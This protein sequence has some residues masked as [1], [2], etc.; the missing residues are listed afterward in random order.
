MG[1]SAFRDAR[2]AKGLTQSQLAA[3]VGVS[4]P[5]L[6]L[7]ENGRAT[8]SMQL[9]WRIAGALETDL[10]RLFPLPTPDTSEAP[11]P[12]RSLAGDLAVAPARPRQQAA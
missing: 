8:P 1:A 10:W 7:I 2:R 4:R 9:A 11:G 3:K 12:S 6:N 5:H